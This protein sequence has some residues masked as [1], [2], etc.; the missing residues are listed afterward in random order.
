MAEQFISAFAIETC[1]VS[2]AYQ[3]VLAVGKCCRVVSPSLSCR[4]A[5]RTLY[6]RYILPL[7][8][9]FSEQLR[10]LN[11]KMDE[12]EGKEKSEKGFRYIL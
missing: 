1:G 2:V 8:W 11:R 9:V 5:L 10:A 4:G 12:E 6:D 7:S 3:W